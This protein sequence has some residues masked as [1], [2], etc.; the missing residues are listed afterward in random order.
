MQIE[1][2][3]NIAYMSEKKK[4][5]VLS[6]LS[7]SLYCEVCFISVNTLSVLFP[8]TELEEEKQYNVPSNC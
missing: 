4:K 2:K 3:Y 8:I 7:Q 1:S 5:T 6:M